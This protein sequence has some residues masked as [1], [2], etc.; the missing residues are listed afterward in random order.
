MYH[1]YPNIF[2]NFLHFGI[3]PLL[4]LLTA[5]AVFFCVF[6]KHENEKHDLFQILR[7]KL[8]RGDITT[9]EFTALCEKLEKNDRFK[10]D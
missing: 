2:D 8:A 1:R 10:Q 9:E 4:L 3:F 5:A 6:R 7:E